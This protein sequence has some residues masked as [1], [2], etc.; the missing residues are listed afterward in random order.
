MDNKITPYTEL[1]IQWYNDVIEFQKELTRS[2]EKKQI[3]IERFEAIHEKEPQ[4]SNKYRE[5]FLKLQNLQL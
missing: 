3:L 1:L 4:Y 5:T 2:K